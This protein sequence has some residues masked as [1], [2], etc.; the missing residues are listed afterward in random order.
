ML[1]KIFPT[2]RKAYSDSFEIFSEEIIQY[3]RT[4]AH[5]NSK[6]HGTKAMH[7]S[8]SRAFQRH[9]EHDLKHPGGSVDLISTKQNKLPSFIDRSSYHKFWD[10][11]HNLL[12]AVPVDE[13]ERFWHL[14]CANV[15]SF[16]FSLF[17]CF[18]ILCTFKKL[19]DV[20]INKVLQGHLVCANLTSFEFSLFSFF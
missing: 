9:Q 15:T 1:I 4:F 17:S 7:L 12:Q 2:I 14:V 19:A 10:T 8:S 5:H 18:F 3:S 20:F 11:R 13:M 16:K 6:R